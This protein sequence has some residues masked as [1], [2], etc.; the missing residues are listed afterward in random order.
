VIAGP[1]G[2]GF[3]FFFGIVRFVS[4]CTVHRRAAAPRRLDDIM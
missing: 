1:S 2:F 4:R 3:S